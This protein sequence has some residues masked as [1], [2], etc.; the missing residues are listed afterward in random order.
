[1]S[2]PGGH[3]ELDNE[4]GGLGVRRE[5]DSLHLVEVVG[6]SVVNVMAESSSDHGQGLQVREVALQLSCLEGQSEC[7]SFLLCRGWKQG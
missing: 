4:S 3:T 6:A 2:L 1:M 7:K 5:A